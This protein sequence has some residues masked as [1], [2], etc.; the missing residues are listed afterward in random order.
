MVRIKVYRIVQENPHF[1]KL[2]YHHDTMFF[3]QYLQYWSYYVRSGIRA[4]KS[5]K[6][7]AAM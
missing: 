3:H 6:L 5:P 1:L 7:C 4:F 2:S